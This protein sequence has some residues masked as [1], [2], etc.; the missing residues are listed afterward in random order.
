M[1]SDGCSGIQ[2]SDICA[3]LLLLVS[4]TTRECQEHGTACRGRKCSHSGNENAVSAPAC[5]VWSLGAVARRYALAAVPAL[6]SA[7]FML[8]GLLLRAFELYQVGPCSVY[9]LRPSR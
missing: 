6:V 3:R 9:T 2:S 7:C 1:L 5:R 4:E 8:W